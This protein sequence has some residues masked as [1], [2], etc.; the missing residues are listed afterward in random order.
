[1]AETLQATRARAG[2]GSMLDGSE[3]RFGDDYLRGGLCEVDRGCRSS[4]FRK[5]C[6]SGACGLLIIAMR[7]RLGLFGARQAERW[8]A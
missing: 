5:E 2:H 4:G 6:V 8:P 3:A 1:M 7:L